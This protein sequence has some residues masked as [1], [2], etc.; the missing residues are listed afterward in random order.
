MYARELGLRANYILKNYGIFELAKRGLSYVL[1]FVFSYGSYYVHVSFLE[2]INKYNEAD[3]RP[4]I[5]N[6]EIFIV[7]NNQDADKL[8]GSGFEFRSAV[9]MSHEALNAGSIAIVI[10]VDQKFAAIHWI[11]LNIRSQKIL[12]G[13]PVKVD[14]S[15]GNAIINGARVLSGFRNKGLFTFL[16]YKV[17]EYLHNRGFAR[18]WSLNDCKNTAAVIAMRKFH[19]QCVA[20]AYWWRVMGI[21]FYIEKS[22]VNK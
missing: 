2:D 18:T 4:A 7:E 12:G 17:R 20:I 11:S 10:F 19:P 14:F 22:V 8:E 13:P 16:V 9:F 1:S 15:S 5:E 3:F 6:M 21:N